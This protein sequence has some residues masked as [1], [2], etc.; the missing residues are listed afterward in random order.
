MSK[1]TPKEYSHFLSLVIPVYKQEKTI[2]HNLKT[3]K[4]A[5][6]KIRYDY[7]IITVIDG[8]VD[9]SFSVINGARLKKVKCLYYEE[10]RG[11]AYAIRLGMHEAV[12]DYVM[13][14]D[15]G[16]E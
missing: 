2:V 14:M 9:K 8:K 16:N 7:E 13:F 3:I 15:S 1:L 11:K 10:N 5:L 4:D 6:D 12:G